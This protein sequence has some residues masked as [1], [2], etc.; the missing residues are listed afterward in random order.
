[1]FV[2]L[3]T[4]QN[5]TKMYGHKKVNKHIYKKISVLS[6]HDVLDGL[7]I[8]LNSVTSSSV[9]STYFYSSFIRQFIVAMCLWEIGAW[10]GA[11]V[12]TPTLSRRVRW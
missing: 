5:Y 11:S 3:V 1:M 9:W 2:D 6:K 4:D 12:P 8:E 7:T 10:C